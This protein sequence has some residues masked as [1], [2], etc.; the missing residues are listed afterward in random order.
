MAEI[1]KYTPTA[2]DTERTVQSAYTAIRAWFESDIEPKINDIFSVVFD[3]DNHKITITPL[4]DSLSY[5]NGTIYVNA[6]EGVVFNARYGIMGNDN[7]TVR[8][9][10]FSSS[11]PV[12]YFYRNGGN[13]FMGLD[14]KTAHYGIYTG[15][16]FDGTQA[17]AVLLSDGRICLSGNTSL[18]QYS[19]PYNRIAANK[20]SLYRI[21][22]MPVEGTDIVFDDIYYLDGG[23][24]LPSGEFKIGNDSYCAIAQNIAVKL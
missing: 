2:G 19:Q 5:F 18:K 8:V 3:D 10:N 16:H 23:M 12:F 20:T 9:K 21:Q 17:S 7:A 22:S 15:K 11:D 1:M 24:S 13:I 6:S 4:Y 14:D